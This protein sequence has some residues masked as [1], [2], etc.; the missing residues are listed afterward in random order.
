MDKRWVAWQQLYNAWKYA[1][2]AILVS[3]QWSAFD[4]GT[5]SECQDSFDRL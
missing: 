2:L 1:L 5:P 3:K 4:V